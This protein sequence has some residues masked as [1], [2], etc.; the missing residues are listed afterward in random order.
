MPPDEG[1]AR[2]IRAEA[3]ADAAEQEAVEARKLAEYTQQLVLQAKEN[4]V[5]VLMGYC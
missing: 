1:Q 4:V 2:A 5:R 3:R